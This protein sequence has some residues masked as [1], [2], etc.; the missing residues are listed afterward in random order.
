[1]RASAFVW[2][3][4]VLCLAA[5]APVGYWV[6][7]PLIA[8]REAQF[9]RRPRRAAPSPGRFTPSVA[10]VAASPGGRVPGWISRIEYPRDRY[11]LITCEPD[12]LLPSAADAQADVAVVIPAGVVGGPGLVKTLVAPMV[13]PLVGMSVA[14]IQARGGDAG[15]AAASW[16]ADA[17]AR[18]ALQSA[19]RAAP[20]SAPFAI[21]TQAA[22]ES[23]GRSSTDLAARVQALGYEVRRAESA[24]ALA[25]APTWADLERSRTPT[26]RLVFPTLGLAW[27]LA[28]ALRLADTSWLPDV[29]AAVLLTASLVTAASALPYPILTT[30]AAQRGRRSLTALVP[31]LLVVS[32]GWMFTGVADLL[33]S[34]R[35]NR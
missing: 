31:W 5:T 22:R 33:S 19:A 11:A 34:R 7:R 15:L 32:F 16:E 8:L 30:A 29:L 9:G 25:D 18:S 24:T 12:Q 26:A 17:V 13:D 1:M 14:T 2:L 23:A 4:R 20:G 35:A 21:R 10:L 27:L 3:L 6:T 28:L